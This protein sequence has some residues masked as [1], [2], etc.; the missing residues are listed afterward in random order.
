MRSIL[1]AG[2]FA[3]FYLISSAAM[4]APCAGF[5][6]VSDADVD[7]CAAVT[8]IKNKFITLGCQSTPTLLYCPSNDVRRDQMALFLSRLGNQSF[9]LGGNAFGSP[10]ILGTNDDHPLDLRVNGQTGLRL[11]KGTITP[12]VIG[13]LSSANGQNANDIG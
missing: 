4:A 7:L 3:G 1:K 2:W 13:F 6:D 12:S 5:Q 8:F 11:Q 9:L 10:G